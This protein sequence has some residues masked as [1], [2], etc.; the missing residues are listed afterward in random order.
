MDWQIL[1]LSFI[2]VFL[3]ELGYKSQLAA[4]ALGG[5]SKFP[6]AVFLGTASALILTS[7]LGVL[8]GQG[9]AEILPTNIVKI[10]AATGFAFI[11]LRLLLS[12]EEKSGESED[13]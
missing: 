12:G 2:A 1:G 9:M 11:G 8:L 5:S 7:F 4:I 3:Y 13:N 6:Q 10:I